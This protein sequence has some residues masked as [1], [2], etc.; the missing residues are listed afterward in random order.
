MR[1]GDRF[2]MKIAK[3]YL[4]AVLSFALLLA[5]P[6]AFTQEASAASN[7]TKISQ[8][9]QV[10][11]TVVNEKGQAETSVTSYS[12]DG[13]GLNNI[14]VYGS[15]TSVA[16]TYDKNGYLLS[17]K[18]FDK[19]LVPNRESIYTLKKN[20][21]PKLLQEFIIS[22]GVSAPE[23]MTAYTYKNGKTAAATYA[24]ADGRE[25]R[26]TE[27]R[28]NGKLSRIVRTVPD[29]TYVY[30]YDK[31]GNITGSTST[32][33]VSG[34]TYTTVKAYK[35]EYSNGRL[36]K[37][38]AA[39]AYSDGQILDAGSTVY[40][41]DNGRLVKKIATVP[42]ITWN[43]AAKKYVLNY[44]DT[45]T[46]TYAYK[47]GGLVKSIS[48]STVRT[49]GTATSAVGAKT[50]VIKYKKIAVK[51]RCVNAVRERMAEFNDA[52]VEF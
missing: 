14:L 46:T 51:N 43:T 25:T 44:T 30:T 37:K 23:G 11:S 15:G 17:E 22:K 1:K 36:V 10:I 29:N 33:A 47:K 27:F 42:D 48:S 4:A 9:V 5:V 49:T 40:T 28:K 38:T 45:T 41:Y 35:N 39:K 34:K 21:K 12:Y 7:K 16:K 6:V 18:R 26:I 50:T 32:L 8:P 24:S 31:H 19:L 2:I 20:G 13:N 52:Y 3:R